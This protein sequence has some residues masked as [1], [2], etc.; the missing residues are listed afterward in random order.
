MRTSDQVYTSAGLKSNL[1]IP[2]GT[3]RERGDQMN[4][5]AMNLREEEL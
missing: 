1:E 5:S 2:C 4:R 3:H